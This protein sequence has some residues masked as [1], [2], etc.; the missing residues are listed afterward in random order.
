MSERQHFCAAFSQTCSRR[1]FYPSN[2]RKLARFS[3]FVRNF[4][5][6]SLSG[7]FLP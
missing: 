7:E 2:S 5:A 1:H 3:E 4:P 6:E